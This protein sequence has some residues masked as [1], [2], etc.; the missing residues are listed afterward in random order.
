MLWNNSRWWRNFDPRPNTQRR[1]R[2]RHDMTWH[3]M[4]SRR[5]VSHFKTRLQASHRPEQHHIHECAFLYCVAP[6]GC[7]L[8]VHKFL[9]FCSKTSSIKQYVLSL[10]TCRITLLDGC[11][12]TTSSPCCNGETMRLL[13]II[14]AT[15][16]N[17]HDM[18]SDS[19]P[20]GTQLAFLPSQIS[21]PYG[22]SKI[23]GCSTNTF[24]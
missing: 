14:V 15:N 20:N 10:A 5:L 6:T 7:A 12:S 11:P 24:Y 13:A 17:C 3:D 2:W 22:R 8:I 21:S 16:N 4:T 23:W 1:K 19:E 18:E 9:D